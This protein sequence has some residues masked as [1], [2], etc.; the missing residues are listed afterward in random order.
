MAESHVVSALVSKR[1]GY[2]RLRPARQT[3]E[4]LS[5]AHRSRIAGISDQRINVTVSWLGLT[6]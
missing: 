1:A 2:L 5:L 6:P 3:Y 4:D